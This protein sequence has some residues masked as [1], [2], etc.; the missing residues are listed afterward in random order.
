MVTI[1]VISLDKGFHREICYDHMKRMGWQSWNEQVGKQVNEFNETLQAPIMFTGGHLK[2]GQGNHVDF[3]DSSGD[4]GNYSFFTDTNAI[5]AYAASVSG[6]ELGIGDKESGEVFVRE[7]LQFMLENKLK[8]DFYE[9]LIKEVNMKEVSDSKISNR[10][11]TAQQIGSLINMKVEDRV[12]EEGGSNFL[13]IMVDEMQNV[14]RMI[15]LAGV[16]RRIRKNAKDS[17]EE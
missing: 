10:L 2:I 13:Q 1:D 7:L 14:G 11:F 9:L 8:K 12:I 15:M 3:F 16:A 5:A 17:K 6:I 4:Y